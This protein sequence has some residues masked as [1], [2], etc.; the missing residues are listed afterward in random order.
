MNPSLEF[1][2]LMRAM[3]M[4]GLDDMTFLHCSMRTKEMAEDQTFLINIDHPKPF[5]ATTIRDSVEITEAGIPCA[6][7]EP[8]PNSQWWIHRDIYLARPE[9]RCILHVHTPETIAVAELGRLRQ[10]H[11]G[12]ALFTEE[13]LGLMEYGGLNQ[14]V[15]L[16]EALGK[17][18]FA[19]LM[20]GHGAIV[21]GRTVGEAFELLVNLQDCCVKEGF[22][23]SDANE[24]EDDII[25]AAHN[26][27]IK[28]GR[29]FGAHS[30]PSER[31]A[32]FERDHMEGEL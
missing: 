25:E 1:A 27:W 5:W 9:L 24:F 3:A 15:G 32:I 14:Y 10:V 21:V 20:E 18:K 2:I 23:P 28:D 13:F 8:R 22:I 30:W 16:V 12:A 11:Q 19:V 7:M 26:A 4:R 17:D 31:D 6:K 29:T